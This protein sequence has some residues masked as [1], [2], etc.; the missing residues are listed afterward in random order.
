VRAG[1]SGWD[2]LGEEQLGERKR[3]EGE[4]DL[5]GAAAL[6]CRKKGRAAEGSWQEI[7]ESLRWMRWIRLKAWSAWDKEKR[8]AEKKKKWL[9]P[10][11]VLLLTRANV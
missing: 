1:G 11:Q 2:G 9:F 4:G 6:Y 10:L 8:A 7:P 5:G 3:R